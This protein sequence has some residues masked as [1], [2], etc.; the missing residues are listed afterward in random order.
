MTT[1]QKREMAESIEL[2]LK[3]LNDWGFKKT[4]DIIGTYCDG[5][6][7]YFKN[8]GGD[9]YLIFSH[10]KT[11]QIWLHNF[12]VWTAIYDAEDLIGNRD[13][14]DFEE[15]VFSYNHQND[16]HLIKGFLEK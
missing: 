8:I 7:L 11:K 9:E 13:T 1:K 14:V 4:T 10:S 16:Y 2:F 6:D 3:N 5:T 15:V 12:D